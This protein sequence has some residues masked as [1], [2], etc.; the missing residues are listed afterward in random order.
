MPAIVSLPVTRSKIMATHRVNPTVAMRLHQLEVLLAVAEAGSIRA[1]ARN[2]GVTPAAVTKSVRQLEESL[3]ARLLDRTQHGVVPSVAGRG[4]LAR[5]RLVQSELRKA[6]EELDQAVGRGGLINIGSGPTPMVLLLP[7]AVMRFQAQRPHSRVRIFDGVHS[8][9]IAMLRDG[10]LDFVLGFRVGPVPH[11]L[12]FRPLFR[13]E[14]G[15]AA[16][17]DHP[18][19]KAHSL[20][21]LASARWLT[22]SPGLVLEHTFKSAEL[23]P[24]QSSL[25]CEGSYDVVAFLA[26]TE[27][28][29]FLSRS[30]LRLPFARD[31]LREIVVKE[32]LPSFDCGVFERSDATPSNDCRAFIRAIAAVA[33]T[34]AQVSVSR[35]SVGLRTA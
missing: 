25:E 20:A 29:A 9:L 27:M 21:Q 19:L 8:T 17:R 4:F 26:H 2:L 28:L 14:F 23:P 18:L 30:L 24:P 6:K 35:R 15:I 16:R 33:R 11:G 5:A 31:S 34:L 22:G 1:A 12:S 10:T 3:S 13:D 32:S 7:E